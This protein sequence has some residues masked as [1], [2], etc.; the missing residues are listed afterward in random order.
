VTLVALHAVQPAAVDCHDRALHNN[1]IDLAQ[2]LS[3]LKSKIVPHFAPE[4]K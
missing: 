2:I 3:S 4:C 1:Q